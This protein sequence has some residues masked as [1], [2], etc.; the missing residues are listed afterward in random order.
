MNPLTY[1]P[2]EG[3]TGPVRFR[4]RDIKS[5][6]VKGCRKFIE[7]PGLTKLD[8]VR[9]PP[10]KSEA[11]VSGCPHLIATGAEPSKKSSASTRFADRILEELMDI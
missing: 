7:H 5:Q 10:Q 2:K 11:A 3:P 1:P 6:T 9:L 4:A 8:D